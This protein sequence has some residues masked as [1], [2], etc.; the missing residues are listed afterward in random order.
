MKC[1]SPIVHPG[2]ATPSPA[3]VVKVAVREGEEVRPGQVLFV[4][5]P[6]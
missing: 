3:L 1:F 6:A 5:R 2:G 4:L